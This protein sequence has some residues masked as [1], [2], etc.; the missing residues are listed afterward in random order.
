M[1]TKVL[2][3]RQ[4]TISK[5][6]GDVLEDLTK[7]SLDMIEKNVNP[8]VVAPVVAAAEEEEAPAAA[9]E[10]D[11]TLEMARQRGDWLFELHT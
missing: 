11:R 8:A 10:P 4:D 3:E 2:Q 5:L 1:E 7:A 6:I 9:P